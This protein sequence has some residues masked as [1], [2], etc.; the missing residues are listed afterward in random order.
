MATKPNVT[1]KVFLESYPSLP[2]IAKMNGKSSVFELAPKST[3]HRG[4][5]YTLIGINQKYLSSNE[6]ALGIFLTIL[7]IVSLVG[8]LALTN[9]KFR[10][11]INDACHNLRHKLKTYVNNNAPTPDLCTQMFLAMRNNDLTA[12]PEKLK[13]EP[14]AIFKIDDHFLSPFTASVLLAAY[15]G[16]EVESRWPFVEELLKISPLKDFE[17]NK[18]LNWITLALFDK[19]DEHQDVLNNLIDI[20]NPA[21]LS[22]RI[23]ATVAMMG[24]WDLLDKLIDMVPPE[25]VDQSINYDNFLND[26]DFQ[27]TFTTKTFSNLPFTAT[28]SIPLLKTHPE[29]ITPLKMAIEQKQWPLATKMLALYPEAQLDVYSLF[30]AVRDDQWPFILNILTTCPNLQISPK[31]QHILLRKACENKQ[32]EIADVMLTRFPD[33]V[34]A[35]RENGSSDILLLM[36]LYNFLTEQDSYVNSKF[37]MHMMLQGAKLNTPAKNL[38][39]SAYTYFVSAYNVSVEGGLA[40]QAH[41]EEISGRLHA[42]FQRIALICADQREDLQGNTIAIIPSDIQHTLIKTMIQLYCPELD[43]IPVNLVLEKLSAYFK[44]K[45]IFSEANKQKI[46]DALKRPD[47]L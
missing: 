3:T 43:S 47:N 7:M 37:I 16:N 6:R 30:S 21:L 39:P 17:D 8:L 35:G 32:W 25:Y 42:L 5:E 24:K 26:A 27:K 28:D 20:K 45:G 10:I 29:L 19:D 33:A 18:W 34:A 13:E 12:I 1:R 46:E 31:D 9:S 22:P 15:T 11:F 38:S 23:V 4:R 44:L 14:D 41:Y 2:E 40:A 36:A